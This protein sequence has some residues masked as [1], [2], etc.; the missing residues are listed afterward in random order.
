MSEQLFTC[1]VCHIPNFTQRGLKAHKCKG[2][3]RMN[4]ETGMVEEVKPASPLAL[5]VLVKKSVKS[6]AKASDAVVVGPEEA[7]AYDLA[8][9]A[10]TANEMLDKVIAHEEA[11][12]EST[13]EPRLQI[14]LQLARAQ[15]QFSM[16]RSEHSAAGGNAKAAVSRRD[17]AEEPADNP[18]GFEGWMKANVPRI[19]RGVA[20]KYVNA[21]R[22]LGLPET[23]GEREIRERVKKL[24]HEA[25]KAGLPMPS[26]SA[27]ARQHTATL[28]GLI[29]RP[30][31]TPRLRLE[32]AREFWHLFQEEGEDLV[33]R[34]ILDDLDK[35]GLEKL[36]EFN[37]WL[38][39]RI[40]AR[41]KTI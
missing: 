12:S 36:R 17:T 31:D 21:F 22:A 32:D 38:R 6:G 35:P 28:T 20:Y 34:G 7:A 30:P 24:R 15:T 37:L 1:P 8:E 10:R 25:G 19:K 33:K 41:L 11:F 3:T 13:L 39:D 18:L 23:A 26:V 29:I 27:L 4:P 2:G 5:A 14:G 9:A 16:T 40:N